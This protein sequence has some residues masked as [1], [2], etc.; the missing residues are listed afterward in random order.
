M[1]VKVSLTVIREIK[2]HEKTAIST[3]SQ[4]YGNYTDSSLY[5][6]SSTEELSARKSGDHQLQNYTSVINDMTFSG[7]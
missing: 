7:Y 1:A 3:W 6:D 4:M 2:K 5:A